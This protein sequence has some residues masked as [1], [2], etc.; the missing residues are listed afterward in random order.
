MVAFWKYD[1]YPFCLGGTVTKVQDNGTVITK[2]YPGMAFKPIA[3]MPNKTG[4][5]IIKELR[6]LRSCYADKC[7]SVLEEYCIMAA[8]MAPFLERK[9]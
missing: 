7:K 6:K 2:E 8:T 4:K 1:L 9:N 3:I 5:K